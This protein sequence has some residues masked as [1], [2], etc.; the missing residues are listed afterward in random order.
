MLRGEHLGHAL[1]PLLTDLPLGC[2]LSAALLDLVGGRSSRRAAQRLVGLGLL[3]VPPTAASG[4]V[5]WS[6]VQE[7]RSRRVGIVHAIGNTAV[8]ACYFASWRARRRDHHLRGRLLG[9]VG[10]ALAV[11]TGYLG[12]HLTLARGVGHGE[13]GMDVDLTTP[14]SATALPRDDA[15]TPPKDA[16]SDVTPFSAVRTT[17]PSA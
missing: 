8:A 1:H 10:G 7:P 5:D 16:P 2:F 15:S 17:R 12:G 3:M 13:R 14:F 6:D 4:L 11:G 9:F